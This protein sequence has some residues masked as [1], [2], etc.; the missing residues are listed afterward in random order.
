MKLS[1]ARGATQDRWV[2]VERSDKMWYTGEG[3]G[4]PLQYVCLENPMNSMKISFTYFY[5][6]LWKCVCVLS[7]VQ[8]YVTPW[9]AAH[10][11]LLSMRFS[12]QEYW[13]GLPFPTLGD[14][15]DLEIEPESLLSPG[16]G[17]IFFTTALPGNPIPTYCNP[18]FN[19]KYYILSPQ[20]DLCLKRM[21]SVYTYKYY[22]D[23]HILYIY[24][25]VFIHT[26]IY[27]YDGGIPWSA[28]IFFLKPVL[29]NAGTY[30]FERD[31][32][33]KM[34]SY[35]RRGQNSKLKLTNIHFVAG[36]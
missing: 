7:H 32:F 3:N 11:T 23:I 13:S 19:I 35:Q 1:H 2:I 17:G 26:H 14:L 9:T 22:I 8:L 12:R 34:T 25:Y 16:L 24:I 5:Y 33:P 28:C 6:N 30:N 18:K 4:K 10:Q 29:Y 15:P 20:S 21:K 31:L 27:Q 36:T